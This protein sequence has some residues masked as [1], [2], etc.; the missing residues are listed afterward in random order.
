MPES[1]QYTAFT[2]G[3]IG[4]Y[5]FTHMPFVLC[6]APTTFQCHMQN[7]LGELNLTYY[8]IYLDDIIV[9]EP[10]EEEHLEHLCIMF[11]CFHEFNLKLKP[12]KCSFFQSEIVYMSHHVSHKG[13]CP[14]RENMHGVEDFPMPDTFTQVRTFCGLAEHYRHS[15]KGF[16]H[17]MRPLYNVLGKEVKM[18]PVQLPH[19]AWEVVRNLKD[20]IQSAP[21]LVIPDFDKPFLLETDTS[22][23]GLGMVLSQKQ[24][25]GC[26]HPIT[27]GGHSLTPAE[28][29]YHSSKLEFLTLKW[30]IMEHFKE[31][32]TYAPFV[33]RT[34]NNPLTYILTT[35]NLDAMGH[36]CIGTLASFEFALE[37]QKGADNGVADTL[38]QVPTCHNPE[39]VWSLMEG[40]IVGAM[41]Q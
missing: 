28:K 38:S 1:Q 19:K 6:N 5:K 34:Y 33:I 18:G 35:P 3:N 16:A 17:I 29:N 7:T 20:K 4:F 31:Y 41:D 36:R 30:S 40:A 13:I 22:K 39:M 12:S 27:F 32:L 8:I 25:D 21:M 24:D 2:V 37:Y 23:E 15:V 14:S 10:T 9:F 11:E 26:Y